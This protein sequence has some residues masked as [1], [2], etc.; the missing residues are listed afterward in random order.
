MNKTRKNKKIVKRA[1]RKKTSQKSLANRHRSKKTRQN[2]RKYTRKHRRNQNK[3]GGMRNPYNESYQTKLS[4]EEMDIIEENERLQ[5]KMRRKQ[6]A[7]R[8]QDARLE[9]LRKMQEMEDAAAVDSM[10]IGDGWISVES[11]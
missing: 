5:L 7:K 10:D 1:N 9:T 2:R 8:Q 6:R 3:R 11:K 4:K